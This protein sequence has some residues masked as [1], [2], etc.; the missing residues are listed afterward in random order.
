MAPVRLE[1]S[2]LF[3]SALIFLLLLA[4][5]SLL[6][7]S[8]SLENSQFRYRGRTF[9]TW[10]AVNGVEK[11]PLD[12]K[13]W[14]YSRINSSWL[15]VADLRSILH[16]QEQQGAFNKPEVVQGKKTSPRETPRLVSPAHVS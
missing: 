2:P 9:R 10:G 8:F 16:E 3:L 15:P 13:I 11:A 6:V 4:P 14:V 12:A 5:P 7:C 1:P